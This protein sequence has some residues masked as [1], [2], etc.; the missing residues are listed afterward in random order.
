MPIVLAG[1]ARFRR[2][3]ASRRCFRPPRC[4]NPPNTGGR[5]APLQGPHRWIGPARMRSRP[6]GPV[7]PRLVPVDTQCSC[8][9]RASEHTVRWD[10]ADT[11]RGRCHSGN[12]R[13]RTVSATRIHRSRCLPGTESRQFASRWCC[14]RSARRTCRIPADVACDCRR[15]RRHSANHTRVELL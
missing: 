11:R 10:K 7:S 4:T 13:E 14:R 8:C 15:G 9:G 2:R 12:C 5:S 6:R 3:T 1:T